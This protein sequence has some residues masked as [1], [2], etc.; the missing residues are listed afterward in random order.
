MSD[1]IKCD[2]CGAVSPDSKGLYV[3]NH[4]TKIEVTTLARL[5]HDAR[6]KTYDICVECTKKGVRVTDEGVKP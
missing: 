5:K 6:H 4:W 1:I 2:A 3:A